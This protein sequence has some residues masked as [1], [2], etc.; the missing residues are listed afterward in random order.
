MKKSRLITL[1]YI[2]RA[3]VFLTFFGHGYLALMGN[4]KWVTY[5][6]TVGFS[7]ER[8]ASLIPYIGGLDIL[9]AITILLKPNKYI[10]LWAVFWAFS[11]ALIRPLSGE[12]IWSFIERGANWGAPLALFFILKNKRF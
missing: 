12:D 2:L 3:A 1:E 6:E 11:T 9:V 10:V 4:K 8:A 5:L 7:F